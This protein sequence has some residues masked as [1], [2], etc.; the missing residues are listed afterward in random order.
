MNI[1][2]TAIETP[3]VVIPCDHLNARDGVFYCVPAYFHAPHMCQDFAFLMLDTQKVM[4]G[5][6]RPTLIPLTQVALHVVS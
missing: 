5:T 6:V 3:V 2:P 1:D 4:S